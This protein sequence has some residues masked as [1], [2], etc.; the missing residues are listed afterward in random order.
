M[1][2]KGEMSAGL[3]DNNIVEQND[4][5]IQCIVRPMLG[6]KSMRCAQ[7]LLAGI[8][9]LH[10]TRKGQLDSPKGQVVGAAK[11]FYSMAF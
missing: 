6:F 3:T 4:R 8:E 10:M 9:T 2:R 7:T 5:A 1:S 11:Q